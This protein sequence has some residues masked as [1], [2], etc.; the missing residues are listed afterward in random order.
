MPKEPEMT[1]ASSYKN[2]NLI[3]ECYVKP[4]MYNSITTNHSGTILQRFG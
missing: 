4:I 2:H 3:F 1:S